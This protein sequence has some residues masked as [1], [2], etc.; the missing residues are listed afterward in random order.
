[1]KRIALV[2]LVALARIA[3]AASIATVQENATAFVSVTFVDQAGASTA[4]S[5]ATY[6]VTESPGGGIV[7]GPTTVSSPGSTWTFI[8][9]ISAHQRK[10]TTKPNTTMGRELN[11]SWEWGAGYTGTKAV[12]YEVQVQPYA[13]PTPA[14]T[15]TP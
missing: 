5:T 3:Y 11:L 10:S 7:A 1:M 8:L 6:K 2:S 14:A 13:P 9:P 4:P 12:S 15:P